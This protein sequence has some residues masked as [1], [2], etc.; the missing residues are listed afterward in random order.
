[1]KY[2]S[3]R[4]KNLNLDF[5]EIFL[6]GL[7]PDGGLFLPK[8]VKR[9]STSELV[10]LKKLNYQDLACEIISNFCSDD[11]KPKL[12]NIIKK[13]YSNFFDKQIYLYALNDS[14]QPGYEVLT[15]FKTNVGF[16]VLINRGWIPNNLKNSAEINLDPNSKY[17]LTGI[18]KKHSIKNPF[19]PK[20]DIN[21]N[22]WF[23]LDK[24]ETSSFTKL[25]LPDFSI[26]LSSKQQ[27]SPPYLKKI[28]SDLPNNHLSY[29]I[30]WYLI[31]I[32]IMIFFL[33]FRK[34]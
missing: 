15:P 24:S 26:V 22:I 19:K 12:T 4:D 23:Y 5:K 11:L 33:Y 8:A 16:N 7:A 3:T 32:A 18:L 27:S 21:N 10:N 30:T 1:M 20:N 17:K 34:R 14:G 6:R 29:A 9:Y 25:E 13:S 28:T 2:F 31:S